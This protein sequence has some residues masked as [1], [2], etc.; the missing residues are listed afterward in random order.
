MFSLFLKLNVS[1][2]FSFFF[3][4]PEIFTSM[5]FSIDDPRSAFSETWCNVPVYIFGSSF[6]SRNFKIIFL[7]VILKCF[8]ITFVLCSFSAI[9]V[10]WVFD[11]FDFYYLSFPKSSLQSWLCLFLSSP[12]LSFPFEQQKFVSQFWNLDVWN[13][14]V[15]QSILS[16]TGWN[17]FLTLPSFWWKLWWCWWEIIGIPW[18]VAASVRFLLLSSHGVLFVWLYT[19]FPL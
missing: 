8:K 14:D 3:W 4:S 15:S 10:V 13:Q 18:F 12:F 16:L 5:W 1:N 9:T 2:F 6:I 17:P 11:N 7:K 19:I